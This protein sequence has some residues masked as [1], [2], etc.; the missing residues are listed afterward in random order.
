[1]DSHKIYFRT[2]KEFSLEEVSAS[3]LIIAQMSEICHSCKHV[4]TLD[5]V[6]DG[7]RCLSCGILFRYF[8]FK[9][10]PFEARAFDKIT[11]VMPGAVFIDYHDF[12]KEFNKKKAKDFFL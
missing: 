10:V 3:L 2:W 4:S 11:A 1:M 6:V 9:S 8:C 12:Q 5:K 7:F